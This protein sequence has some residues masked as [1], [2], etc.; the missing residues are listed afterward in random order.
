[1]TK[2]NIASFGMSKQVFEYLYVQQESFRDKR[3]PDKVMHLLS[4]KVYVPKN[5]TYI[6]LFVWWSGLL[7]QFL[8]ERKGFLRA[9]EYDEMLN[10]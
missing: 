4:L 7:A 5:I 6:S 10:V 9:H 3:L 2:T 8:E 1:M